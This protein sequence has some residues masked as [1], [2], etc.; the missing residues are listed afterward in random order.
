MRIRQ[1]ETGAS[2][3]YIYT[4]RLG[5]NICMPNLVLLYWVA[6]ERQ[7]SLVP[8]IRALRLVFSFDRVE[9]DICG[10]DLCFSW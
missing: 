10:K 6:R 2:Y 3:T 1:F 5:T 8:N 4:Y 9:K 7:F